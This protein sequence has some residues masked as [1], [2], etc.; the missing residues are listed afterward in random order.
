VIE[1]PLTAPLDDLDGY[2]AEAGRIL[3]AEPARD[4]EAPDLGPEAEE[5]RW[6]P[7]PAEVQ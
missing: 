6:F 4:G 3:A 1:A 2:L 7:N 5:L